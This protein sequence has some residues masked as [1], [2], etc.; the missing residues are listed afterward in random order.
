MQSTP[1]STARAQEA[2]TK[3]AASDSPMARMLE[4]KYQLGARQE[5]FVAT[6]TGGA[7][8]FGP[9]PVAK[10]T[11]FGNLRNKWRSGWTTQP[12]YLS[13]IMVWYKELE[14]SR[15]LPNRRRY[16]SDERR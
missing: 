2:L 11:F 13:Y 16:Y 10:K 12:T 6:A 5:K 3:E 1:Y 15:F 9:P 7:W 14:R 8:G 4:N